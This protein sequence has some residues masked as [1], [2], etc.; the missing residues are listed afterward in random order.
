[1]AT[2][3]YQES[4][5]R[6]TDPIRLFKANDPYYFE[7]ENIPLKQLQE[8]CLWLKDQVKKLEKVDLD[9]KRGD[10]EELRPYANGGDRIIHVKP[11]RYTARINDASS[12]RPLAYLSKVMGQAL[13]EVEQY[14]AAAPNPGNLDN[15]VNEKLRAALESFKSILSQDALEMN[16]LEERAFTWPVFN[17]DTPVNT[18]GVALTSDTTIS[19]GGVDLNFGGN[20][21]DLSPAVISQALLWAKSTDSTV[22]SVILDTFAISNSNS[23]WSKLPRLESYFIKKWRGIAR[24]AIVDVDSELSI[25]VPQFDSEDFSYTN[26]QGATIPVTGVQSRIDLV[27]IYSKPV[28]ASGVN[29]LTGT[30]K[31]KITKPQLGIVKGAGIRS[32]FKESSN[33]SKDYITSTGSTPSI[34]ASPGD[35]F[36]EDLGFTAASGNDI[37]YDI[38]GSLPAPDDIMN[39]A[40]LLSE[41]LESEAY[42]LVG[43]SILPVAY[44]WVTS[45]SQLVLPTDVIDIRPFLRTAELAYNERAGIAAAFPQL[46]L[47]NPAVGKSQLDYEVKRVHDNSRE[48]R[49]LLREELRPRMDTIATGYIFGGWYFGTEG[50]LDAFES[51]Q[52]GVQDSADGSH[53]NSR[54]SVA[55][56]YYP[57]ID[58]DSIPWYPDWDRAYW[59]DMPENNIDNPG[60][61]PLDYVNTFMSDGTWVPGFAGQGDSSLYLGSLAKGYTEEGYVGETGSQAAYGSRLKAFYDHTDGSLNVPSNVHF[62]YI[63]KRIDF[64][65]PSDL[66][67]YHVDFTLLNTVRT[68]KPHKSHGGSDSIG[69]PGGGGGWANTTDDPGAYFG[70]W[71]E[72]H[73]NYFIIYLAYPCWR[74]TIHYYS[75]GWQAHIVGPTKKSDGTIVTR[76]SGAATDVH[77]GFLVMTDEV[78][79]HNQGAPNNSKNGAWYYGNPKAMKCT[80]PTV[81]W[82][83]TGIKAGAENYNY[84]NLNNTNPTIQVR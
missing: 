1:M 38:R 50:A 78:L 7:V 33:L 31:Q 71:V 6:F 15:D 16:G 2:L 13:G 46:S 44:V 19:Y 8:N 11:G 25:E 14:E 29:I 59:C 17:A 32:T 41:K 23:G 64:D 82:T 9:V 28:D 35:Q 72:K 49:Q 58:K 40:P 68:G 21:A 5:F 20:Q 80:Y 73:Y 52:L 76:R 56:K 60:K 18:T 83:M 81:N 36:N 48:E 24:L 75:G 84:T 61:K 26:S 54:E 77:S 53:A 42:E 3:D 65:R 51:I 39:L 37:A 4:N 67:D 70:D 43:Q 57:G 63:K 79:Y 30:G 27:F 55:Q 74:N 34:L 45:D 66:I 22:E 12:K 10:L 47:A 62:Q 69:A